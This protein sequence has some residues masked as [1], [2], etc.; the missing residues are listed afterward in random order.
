MKTSRLPA[1]RAGLVLLATLTVFAS[2]SAAQT[3]ASANGNGRSGADPEPTR[4]V[5]KPSLSATHIA[6]EYGNDI[7]IVGRE[8][9]AA[10]RLTSDFQ[11]AARVFGLGE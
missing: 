10:R 9:G 8:G 1:A 7:W 4:L 3:L 5:R 2:S 11:V 6:F